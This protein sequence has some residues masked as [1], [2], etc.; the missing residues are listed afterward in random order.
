MLNLEVIQDALGL[1][2]VNAEGAPVTAEQG[3]HGL[4]VMNNLLAE[5]AADGV[6]VGH[7]PQVA[8][9]ED[10]PGDNSV[11]LAVQYNMA[12]TMAPTYGKQVDPVVVGLAGRF[13]ARL[14]RD[15]VIALAEPV[16]SSLPRSEGQFGGYSILTDNV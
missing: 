8:T 3:E 9:G 7:F 1:I 16:S 14:V 13:Y 4:R 10:F 2:G 5:W 12:L 15:A 11:A 6:D